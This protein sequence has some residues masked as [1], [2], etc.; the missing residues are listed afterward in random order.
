MGEVVLIIAIISGSIMIIT[1][2][3]VWMGIS[4]IK[5]RE[6]LTK[7]ASE[8]EMATL[9]QQVVDVQQEIAVLK[10]EVERLIRIAKGGDG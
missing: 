10:K 2:G 5:K 7:G 4:Y 9:Q 3:C 1:L 6:G 8:R